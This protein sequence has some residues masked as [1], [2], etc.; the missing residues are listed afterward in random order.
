MTARS[1]WQVAASIEQGWRCKWIYD[2][3]QLPLCVYNNPSTTR[4][5]FSV[6]LIERPAKVRNIVA[7]KM[8]LPA[9]GDYSSEMSTIRR[10]TAPPFATG[11]SGDWG[12][13]DALLAGADAWHSVV[14]G[15]LPSEALAI[16]RAA[17]S[18]D[19][20]L[21]ASINKGFEPMSSTFKEFGSFRVIFAVAEI[22][23]IGAF[24]P[25]R[26]VLGLHPEARARVAEAIYGL[27]SADSSAHD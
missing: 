24:E 15:L 10:H 2:V 23:G 1:L 5:T 17:R 18:G 7:I 4:F 27:R 20:E 14:S 3:G 9:D 6:E 22:I 25:P 16:T 19:T 8:P 21:A 11:Y 12:A 26:P 13:A